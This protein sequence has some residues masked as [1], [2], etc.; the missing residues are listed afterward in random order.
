MQKDLGLQIHIILDTT[1][2]K[3]NENKYLALLIPRAQFF[4]HLLP[5]SSLANG[6]AVSGNGKWQ[7]Q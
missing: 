6:G 7:Q 2:S 4:D 1:A 3:L 5:P